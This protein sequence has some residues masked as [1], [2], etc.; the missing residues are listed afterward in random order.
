MDA[1]I[2]DRTEADASLPYSGLTPEVILDAVDS[3]GF[4]SDGRL[5]ALNSYEN[6]VYEVGL[7]E[8][9]PLI[10]K[11][12]R[13]GRWS[14][15]QILEEHAFT[16]ELEAHE[17]PVAA[18]VA[19]GRTTLFSHAGFRFALFPKRPG[20]TPEL[21]DED[22]LIVLGRLIG[23]IHAVGRSRPFSARPAVNVTSFGDASLEFL[24]NGGFI[25]E[26][27]RVNYAAL[28]SETLKR[29]RRLYE[30]AAIPADSSYG[31]RLHGDCHPG[32]VL[33]SGG[34][35]HFVDFD[36]CRTGPA[37]QDLWMLLSGERADREL[38]LSA[39]LKGYL[40]FS[41][42]DRAELGLIEA[43]RAL[44]LIHY[45]AWLAGRYDDPAFKAA[46]PWFFSP[47][48]WE[49][50]ILALREQASAMDDP[51]LAPDPDMF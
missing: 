4:S 49:Q 12:Y 45:S 39:L 8:G 48:Y 23:R 18:P 32:N 1:G 6:R 14:D 41:D 11:F 37:V 19:R 22:T 38:A 26:N 35:A 28:A 20:R 7:E 15:P 24:L 27:L 2:P 34:G 21:E 33:W 3:A 5:L 44:R 25:P 29:A 30:K 9:P 43:L 10:A 16:L 51:P 50:Q 36:D 40:T 47:R 31:I 46:F 42:F 13:S 17:I